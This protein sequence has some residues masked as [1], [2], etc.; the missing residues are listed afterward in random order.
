[1]AKLKASLTRL[2]KL[3]LDPM[4]LIDDS[5]AYVKLRDLTSKFTE[6]LVEIDQIFVRAMKDNERISLVV[7]GWSLT[8]ALT[9]TMDKEEARRLLNELLGLLENLKT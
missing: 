7:R 4:E 5:T 6:V 9:V 8:P 3:S 1:V 2:V